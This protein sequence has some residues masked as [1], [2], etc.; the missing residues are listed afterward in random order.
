MARS[1]LPQHRRRRSKRWWVAAGV[2][3]LVAVGCLAVGLTGNPR[4]LAGPA[5]IRPAPPL[6]TATTTPVAP[7]I[8]DRSAPTALNIPA[9]GVSVSVSALGLNADG[10]V[11]VPTD[12][13]QP[14]WYRLGPSPGQV[15]SA[16]IL[17]HVD[18]YRGPA[19]FFQLRSLKAGDPVDVILADGATAHFVVSTVAMYPKAQFPAQQV[20]GSHGDSE[21]QLVTCGGVFDSRTGGYL[22]N[23]VAYS[24]LVSTT[25]TT[26]PAAG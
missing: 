26:N 5:V 21:L 1:S 24:T 2:L 15:G 7:V 13:Q 18:S 3:L 8:L 20:Y 11:Q 14:G 22:S 6:T 25:P 17:G 4:R 12:F 10:T 9:I 16:V 23:I 19:V